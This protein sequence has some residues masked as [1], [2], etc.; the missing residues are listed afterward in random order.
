SRVGVP[1]TTS[2][3]TPG[4]FCNASATRAACSR[5]PPQTGHSRMV[6]FFIADLLS[7]LMRLHPAGD[8]YSIAGFKTA[9]SC[10]CLDL[11]LAV[12][13]GQVPSHGF[14]HFGPID[15]GV[16]GR[17]T[18]G[19]KVRAVVVSEQTW[20]R[21]LILERQHDRSSSIRTGPAVSTK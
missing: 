13:R 6:T 2:T 21:E 9:D 19:Q 15:R 20:C 16:S 7:I 1:F 18:L 12:G 5:V 3:S 4:S 8:Y 11:S 14:A 10:G 17:S